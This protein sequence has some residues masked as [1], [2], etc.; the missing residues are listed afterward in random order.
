M[1]WMCMRY[2]AWSDGDR[3]WP[4]ALWLQTTE[5]LCTQQLPVGVAVAV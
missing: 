1:E 4:C 2:H 5:P 3:K